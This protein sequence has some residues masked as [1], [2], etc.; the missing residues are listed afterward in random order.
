MITENA[1]GPHRA[2]CSSSGPFGGAYVH[3]WGIRVWSVGLS[4]RRARAR[5][6]RVLAPE[7]LAAATRSR[8]RAASSARS[9]PCSRAACGRRSRGAGSERTNG[10]TAWPVTPPSCAARSACSISGSTSSSGSSGGRPSRRP[11]PPSS[12]CA[13]RDAGRLA[14]RTRRAPRRAGRPR[15]RRRAAACRRGSR[16]PG[17]RATRAAPP[18]P[19][20]RAATSRRP[21][22]RAPASA[23][24]ARGRPRRRADPGSR[25]ARRRARRS[26]SHADAG[27]ARDGE[28]AA[29]GRRA[30]RALHDRGREIA[31]PDLARVGAEPL[32][33]VLRQPDDDLAVEDAD[34]RRAP[35]PPRAP[36]APTR[37]R[38][39]RPRRAG[40]RA[41]RASSRARR[42]RRRG[43]RLAHLVGDADHADRSISTKRLCPRRAAPRGSRRGGTPAARARSSAAT[44]SRNVA[45]PPLPA[46]VLE[47]GVDERLR[48]AAA[49]QVGADA[50]PDPHLVV[51]R[52]RS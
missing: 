47:P 43:E 1:V 17:R 50:E 42:R 11:A 24:A 3:G 13:P 30:D 35:R 14:P 2:S 46:R 26:P 23:R 16:A 41:R 21:R 6:V 10:V 49:R 34:R 44:Q 25:D 12:Q 20:R 15:R 39:R 52:G 37:A 19:A 45:R 48:E 5:A 31:R 51:P 9:D 29:D 36:A 8:P 38:P 27:R 18:S 33:L 4:R 7:P 22:R 32:E 40:S 28:R